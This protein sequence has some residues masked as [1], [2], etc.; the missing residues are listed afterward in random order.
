ME[1]T[2]TEKKPRGK[3]GQGSVYLPHNSRNWWIKFSVAG[4]V[5]QCSANTEKKRE[6][7]DF[8]RNEILKYQNG[9][10]VPEGKVTVDSLYEV[11]LG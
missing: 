10:A 5:I 8:L 9:D 11:L 3:R 4:R 7:Q 1:N 2:N 6:A